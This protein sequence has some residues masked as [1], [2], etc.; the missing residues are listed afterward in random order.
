MANAM[1]CGYKAAVVKAK[2][3]EIYSYSDLESKYLTPY[4]VRSTGYQSNTPYCVF[5]V[6]ILR[7]SRLLMKNCVT[8]PLLTPLKQPKQRGP[9]NTEQKNHVKQSRAATTW[10]LIHGVV[11]AYVVVP[12]KGGV[13][14]TLGLASESLFH[15]HYVCVFVLCIEAILTL[16]TEYGVH[17]ECISP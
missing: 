17:S 11:T 7:Y 13:A 3:T 6:L 8:C 4:G 1:L 16:H 14:E 10:I 12:R 9:N 2:C 5:F 15:A